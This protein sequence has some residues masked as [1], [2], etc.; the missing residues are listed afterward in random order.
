MTDSLTIN[1]G[2]VE[3]GEVDMIDEVALPD[4]SSNELSSPLILTN[5]K[6]APSLRYR[7]LS[8]GQRDNFSAY[9]INLGVVIAASTV[10]FS[11]PLIAASA[12]VSML[13]LL[14]G[15][16]KAAEAPDTENLNLIL[17]EPARDGN[18]EMASLANNI[19]HTSLLEA[20]QTQSPYLVP[21]DGDAADI[22]ALIRNAM[23]KQAVID[24]NL[25]LPEEV[26]NQFAL[27]FPENL[28]FDEDGVLYIR[29]T[30]TGDEDV[31][32]VNESEYSG[33]LFNMSVTGGLFYLLEDDD[34]LVP[35]FIYKDVDDSEINEQ[36]TS[37]FIE[38]YQ[39]DVETILSRLVVI[40]DDDVA[41]VEVS[42][43]VEFKGQILFEDVMS[44]AVD[45]TASTIAVE[46]P[47]D[48][49]QAYL[50]G[51]DH[52]DYGGSATSG[53]DAKPREGGEVF[54][55]AEDNDDSEYRELPPDIL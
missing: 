5:Q 18:I 34:E 23:Q 46:D 24:V 39:D 27:K 13:L 32:L 15:E 6:A 48:P 33:L 21:V 35:S 12:T 50:E 47:V 10:V 3:L 9:E 38:F 55:I 28:A 53:A 41:S 8:N 54:G 11:M 26:L 52:F 51:A 36:E 42:V 31:L 25:P 29:D 14:N 19:Q 4:L 16:S 43:T 30:L 49:D 20:S 44:I 45:G 17:V 22:G 2:G 7:H 37:T 1:L 40:A